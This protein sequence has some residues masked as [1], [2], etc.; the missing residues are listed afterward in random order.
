[1]RWAIVS[2]TL[3]KVMYAKQ[4]Q[5]GAPWN[6]LQF[7]CA[8]DRV[9]LEL[10]KANRVRPARLYPGHQEFV[11]TKTCIRSLPPAIHVECGAVRLKHPNLFGVPTTEQQYIFRRSI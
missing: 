3:V 2:Y 7:G 5:E 6:S 9:V 8:N 4:L 10:T 11:S 1:M